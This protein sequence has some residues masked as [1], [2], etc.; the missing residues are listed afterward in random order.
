MRDLQL[1]VENE[2]PGEADGAWWT[3][4]QSG[5][6]NQQLSAVDRALCEYA[7]RLTRDPA[8]MT[9]GDLDAL[10]AHGLGDESLHDAIQ[11]IAYF[12]YINRI[13]DAVHVD[14]EDDMEPYPEG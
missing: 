11:V 4:W 7:V 12:N 14:L 1:E 2:N 5:W 13:A 6:Q 10:R 8:R 9:E 3:T